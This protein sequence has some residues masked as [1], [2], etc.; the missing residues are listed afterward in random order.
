MNAFL[1]VFFSP[2]IV[3]A[4]KATACHYVL[5]TAD[6]AKAVQPGAFSADERAPP[7][8]SPPGAGDKGGQVN[9]TAACVFLIS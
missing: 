5:P 1:T 7:A 8:T 9:I 3:L 4:Y 2:S 6:V